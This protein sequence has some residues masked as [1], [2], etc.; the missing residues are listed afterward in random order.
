MEYSM[1]NN[2]K[3]P[4]GLKALTAAIVMACGVSSATE[5]APYFEMWYG[6]D[7]SYPAPT[8]AS[9]QQQLGMK[10]VTLA[11]TIAKNGS[12]DISNDGS[13]NNLL[14]GTM[15]DDIANFSRGGGRV[16]MSFGGAAGTY[17]EAV[18]SVDQMVAMIEGMIQRH[19][20]RSVDFDVEGGQL[21][22]TALNNTRN[23]ALKQL[24]AKYPDLFVSFTLPVLPTGLTSPGVAVVRSA[25]Q[26]G[27]RVDLVNVMA[28]DYGSSISNG[29]KMGDLAVQAATSLFS[30]IKP[31]FPTKTDAELWAMIGVTPMIGQNDISTEVF[32]LADAQTLTAFAQQ[33][34]LGRIAWWSFQRDRIGSGSYGEYS[35]VNT[36]NFDFYNIFKAAGSGGTSPTPTPTPV[37]PTPTPVT[38]T[39][40]PVTPTPTPVTPTPTPGSCYGAWAEGSTYSVGALV[41]YNG[42][43]YQAQVSHTAYAGTNWNPA[44][45]PTLWKDVGACSG[46]VPTP[47]PVTP[48]PTPVTPTPTPVTPTPTP[49]TPTPTPV[50]PTPAGTC[51]A[52]WNTSSV[53]AAANTK[54]SYNGHNYQNKWWTQGDNPAQSGEWGVWKDLGSCN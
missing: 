21:S 28:M 5:I 48:T 26:A 51:A 34:G 32:T 50:T 12:C 10:G 38:P 19:N 43:N 37:T 40:T 4:F 45:S 8:L 36:A 16:V 54:V 11:F 1:S 44:A 52:A 47:T 33:K 49:V 2:S 30:Q 53:Y 22:N 39:P 25:A 7:T 3:K 9:A 41:T 27:V 23:S 46:T 20:I 13:G 42:R 15:K 29:K 14:D 17:V 6:G 35:R 24:Q 31:I 18:C